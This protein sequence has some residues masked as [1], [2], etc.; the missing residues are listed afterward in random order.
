MNE[1][2]G[3]LDFE[4]AALYRDGIDALKVAVA[5]KR[6]LAP[7]IEGLN[8]LAICPSVYADWVEAFVFGRGRLLDR[9]RLFVGDGGPDRSAVANF[10]QKVVIGR[11]KKGGQVTSRIDA[12]GLDQ[13]NIISKWLD[14]QGTAAASIPLEPLWVEDRFSE[15]EERV[16][17]AARVAA[18]M[19]G[20]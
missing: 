15:V 4:T 13:V 12:Q 16:A 10:L 2:A 11:F 8:V 9:G 18:G 14:R 20:L 17:Q 5:R 7:A 19:S 3:R 6:L 1:A